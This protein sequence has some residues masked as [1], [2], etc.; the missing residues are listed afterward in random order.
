MSIRL[1]P[2]VLAVASCSAPPPDPKMTQLLRQ[3]PGGA[4]KR[5]ENIL[6]GMRIEARLTPIVLLEKQRHRRH[7]K[8]GGAD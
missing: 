1:D 8:T 7:E 3:Y 5:P 6:L 4:M 2:A